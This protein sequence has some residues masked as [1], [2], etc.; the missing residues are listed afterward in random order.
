MLL[1]CGSSKSSSRRIVLAVACISAGHAAFQI[2]PEI[3][4]RQT[5]DEEVDAVVPEEDGTCEVP[6]QRYHGFGYG[7][8]MVEQYGQPWFT[9]VNLF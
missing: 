2:A 4:A 9:M 7:S 5:V 6:T 1:L 3:R 8:T